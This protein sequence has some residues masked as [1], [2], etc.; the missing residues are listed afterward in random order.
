[1]SKSGCLGLLI[2]GTVFITLMLML[3]ASGESSAVGAAGTWTSTTAG[4]GYFDHTYPADYYYDATLTL[5]S[6]GS[7]SLTLRCTDVVVNVTGGESALGM[8]GKSQT[9]GGDYSVL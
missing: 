2:S 5:G 9:L 3:V 4:E 8:I 7:G 1:M 6:G